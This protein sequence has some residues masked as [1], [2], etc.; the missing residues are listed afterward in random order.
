MNY[1]STLNEQQL[2]AVNHIEGPCLVMA[3]AGSGKTRV[4]TNRIINLIENGVN[5]Y[6]ILAITF[7]NKAAK[8][9]RDR[10][11]NMYGDIRSFIGTFHSLG[12]RIVRENFRLCGLDNN[13]T[14]IDSEDSLAVIKKILKNNNLDP[15]KYSPY[16]IRNQISMIKNEMLSDVEMERV[17]NTDFDKICVDIY[18]KYQEILKT[19]NVVDFDDLLVKP[20]ELFLNND[21]I[22]EHYQNKYQY[23]LV[24]EYQ[25]TNPVQY[26]FTKLLASKYRNLFVVGDMNQSIYGFRQADY[27]NIL[28]FEKDYPEANIIKLEENYRSTNNILNAANGVIKNNKQRKDLKLWSKNGDGKKIKYIR[29]NDEKHEVQIVIDEVEKLLK[30]GKKLSDIAILYRTNGQSRVFEE[31]FITKNIPV[32]VIGSYYFY[33]RKEIK[34][35]IAYLRFIYNTKDDVSLR[36]IINTPKRGIGEAAVSSLENEALLNN[37]SMYEVLSTKKELAFKSIIEDLIEDSKTKS[38]TDLIECI[39]V[40][41]GMRSELENDKSL[42][43]D[44]RL[45]YLEEFKSITENFE[46]EDGNVD[47]GEFLESIS[48]VAD[49][50]LH[51][52]NDEAVTLMTI[53]SAKGLEFTIVFLVGMEEGIFPHSNSLLESDGLEEERRLCY[54]GITRAKE[55]LY[56]T[57]AKRR[58]LYGKDNMNIPSRFIDEID[59]EYLDR[60]NCINGIDP[61]K[62]NKEKMYNDTD[63]DLKVGDTINHDTYGIGIILKI[64]G[65][66][67]E[68]AFKSGVKKLM[69]NHKAIKKL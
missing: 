48:L 49:K 52:E 2:E 7:T 58:M 63:T 50:T 33:N 17:F 3:G 37:S 14:I 51:E 5:D 43:S 15:K 31:G 35:L 19:S 41:T 42:E 59:Q 13:F 39:L 34:D 55:L 40:K 68:I 46:K 4:L 28:N 38:L 61:V 27:K 9:M 25:D 47:L 23:I 20:V 56:I 16:Q 11:F 22:L 66:I 64:D 8:E 18:H 53:H 65:L 26:R 32:K 6:N 21:E 10:V 36:R 57:N 69:K 44:L 67:A 45:E 54:V 1:K 24:D 30:E 62:I 12:L 60:E 29:S